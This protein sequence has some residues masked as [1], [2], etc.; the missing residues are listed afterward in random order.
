MTTSWL[1]RAVALASASAAIVAACVAT[2]LP[3]PP[4]LRPERLELTGEDAA[5][6][7]TGGPGAADPAGMTLRLRN[8]TRPALPS[9]VLVAADGSFTTSVA[10]ALSDTIRLDRVES[11]EA[12][13]LVHLARADGAAVRR[14]PAPTD[15]DEDGFAATLDCADDDP[16]AFPEAGELCDGLDNDCNGV[17]DE[18]G[19]C[20]GCAAD[21]DCGD[22][23]FCNGAE[24]CLFG[25]C[26]VGPDPCD[27]GDPATPDGCD[28]SLRACLHGDPPPARCGNGVPETGEACDDGNV[29]SGDGCD[30]S[31]S[32][33]VAVAESCNG[34]DD[35]CDGAVDEELSCGASCAADSDCDDVLYCTSFAACVDGECVVL[36]DLPCDDGDPGTVDICRETTDSCEH[37]PPGCVPVAEACNGL[38]DD[39]DGA[40]DEGIELGTD[41]LNCGACGT[42]CPAGE[43]C[44]E[45]ICTA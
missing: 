17:V 40:V 3:Y 23:G 35:D 10:G 11:G 29:L 42:A 5:L 31:C 14:V 4:D 21:A 9:E 32:S 41:P 27:D 36:P 2:P 28:P 37:T 22:R 6:T 12:R 13:V 45:G 43:T 30:E 16:A 33:C 18:G 39:C 1:G 20:S 8:A 38:D 24:V 15:G 26:S 19:A 25:A 34:L 44:V 7:L